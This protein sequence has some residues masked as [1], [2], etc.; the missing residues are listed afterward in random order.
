MTKDNKPLIRMGEILDYDA[1]SLY[2]S[3]MAMMYFPSGEAHKLDAEQIRYYNRITN[4]NK[5]KLERD[6]ED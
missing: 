2:P 6:S 1:V 5:I 4:L 3:A